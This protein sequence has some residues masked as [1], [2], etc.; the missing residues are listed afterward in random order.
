MGGHELVQPVRT[1]GGCLRPLVRTIEEALGMIAADVPPELR[2]LPRWTFARDLLLEAKRTGKKR[3][4]RI[5][6]R[7]LK[8]ALTKEGWLAADKP[9]S[10]TMPPTMHETT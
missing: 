1:A 4:N 6:V 10:P 8:Q 2:K 5:A 9:A 7:Q 3:D